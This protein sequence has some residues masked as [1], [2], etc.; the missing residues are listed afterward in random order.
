MKNTQKGFIGIAVAIGL[1]LI[2]L[3]SVGSYLNE[4]ENGTGVVGGNNTVNPL[5]IRNF[6]GLT[7][8][9]N[10][11]V[12]Q[13]GKVVKVNVGENALE[14]GTGGGGGSID[15]YTDGV[16][17]GS[18]TVLNLI[19]TGSILLTDDG[20][21]GITIDG[22]LTQPGGSTNDFQYNGGGG[23]FAGASGLTYNAT[24]NAVG[25]G[26]AGSATHKLTIADTAL[27]GSG[28][29]AGSLI[30]ASQ[31]WNTSGAPTAIK[32][33]VTNTA[34]GAGLLMDLQV[35]GTSQF[36]VSKAGAVTTTGTLD[37]GSGAITTLGNV[38]ANSFLGSTDVR[39]GAAGRFLFNGRSVLSSS[40]DGIL[41]LFNAAS[42]DF[43]RLNFG[44]T[45]SSFP[46]WKRST[47]DLQ[48][49]LADDSAYTNVDALAYKVSGTTVL[50][51]TTLGSTIVSS[52]LTSVGTITT[53]VWSGTAVAFAKGGTGLTSA[54]DDTT[55]VSSGSAWV[56][57]A[58]PNCTDT[59][60][61]HINYTASTNAFSCGTSSS[62]GGSGLTIGTTTITSGSGGNVLYNNAGTL[63]EMT[64]TGTGTVLA[65]ATSPTFVTPA[66]GTP[67][68]GTLT[69][70]TG[71]PV[72][73]GISGLG[74]GIATWL[75]TPSSANLLTAVTDETG[76]GVAVFGTAPTFTTNLTSPK[77]IG[78]TGTTSTLTLQ[79]T[80]G[81]GT[82]NADM[83]FLVGNNGGTE[84]L[85]ISN[86]GA[87]STSFNISANNGLFSTLVRAG[88][89]SSFS[90]NG[91]SKL[92]SS[93]DGII[94]LFNN[95]GSDFTRLNFGGTTSSFPALTRSSAD[96]Q[97]RLADSSAYTNI[98]ALAYKVS[99]TTVLS[100]TT[101]GS[102]IVSSSL[103]SLGTITTGVWNG[104]T[105]AVANGGTGI[106][107]FGTG[108]ATWLGTPSSANLA[109]AI[110]NE[111][112]SGLLVF[113]TAPT[114]A[115]TMT[116]GTASGTTGAI[117]FKGTTSGTVTLTVAAAAGTYTLTLP[118]T[119][120]D[121]GQVLSTNGSGVT[122]WITPGSGFIVQDVGL[123]TTGLSPGTLFSASSVTGDV[124][125]ITVQPSGG[126]S[127]DIYRLAKDGS[128]SYYITNTTTLSTSSNGLR[129]VAVT[130]SY[131]YVQAVIGGTG[132]MRRYDIADLANVTSMTYTATTNTQM[133]SDG[134]DI[135]IQAASG[136]FD[137][138]TISGTTM[139]N[140]SNV[141]YTSS[142][143]TSTATSNGT[144][145]W[146]TDGTPGSSAI[147]I[148]KYAVAGG[149][150]ASSASRIIRSDA[151]YT[152]TGFNFFM[153]SS[154]YLGL[155]WGFNMA[156]PTAISGAFMHLMALTLP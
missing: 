124:L 67:S 100:G 155:N 92:N 128:G 31:T 21:G 129:G 7:D 40:A 56:A 115:S 39:A 103:T 101:L 2:A 87:I 95:A 14:F 29:L 135:Y 105:I 24:S 23:T 86:A 4:G 27:A 53:G 126:S 20:V 34:S 73:S 156:T 109:S 104:T 61:N 55:L 118:T 140:A 91:R 64:T 120:G 106:T 52:S 68:S 89:S 154:A 16:L 150:V 76:T 66:L 9:P 137:K 134:T 113:G 48:A 83:I 133:W 19:G 45:T 74:T 122:S 41:N 123:T 11:Y 15:L 144:D 80:S 85:R 58:I 112:G 3:F 141:A 17:N 152:T 44:G 13:A 32:L 81:V 69:N 110:T 12:G 59:G 142:G 149:A 71:L 63:G 25:I 37:T 46:A 30:D 147:T 82:T 98:D 132:S 117:D 114:F 18:Q 8:T 62:G 131:V 10:S 1:G 121:S 151:W 127:V 43:G 33:N 50:S 42:N 84:A 143:F 111:T 57:S 93:A 138:Y 49:R 26:T 70:A 72:A 119:D 78:G 6:L 116:I 108:V 94:E 90:F 65:L 148:R 145:V 54:S 79:T 102:T 47:V 97:V 36:K 28:S 136:T 96:L 35:G 99:G 75:A 22:A 107:S 153:G 38:T 130:T 125:F 51:G 60:G 139:T 77:I 146:M 88:A 5:P